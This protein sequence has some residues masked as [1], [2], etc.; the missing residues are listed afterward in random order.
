MPPIFQCG[1]HG[2]LPIFQYSEG[3]LPVLSRLLRSFTQLFGDGARID[4]ERRSAVLLIGGISLVVALALGLIGYGY[5]T[6]RIAPKH[7]LVLR[8]GDRQYDYA[9]IE[10]RI[11]SDLARGIFDTSNV[12]NS[13]STSVARIQREEIIRV[14]ARQHGLSASQE[15]IDA[16]IRDQLGLGD[17]VSHNE[18]AGILRQEVLR[19]ELPLHDYLE[20]V[21]ADALEAKLKAEFT[22]KL[23]PESE[24]V[25]LLLIA[26]GSQA[27]A[28]QARQALDA[29]KAF[30]DVAKTYSQDD[31]ASKGGEF[32]WAPRELLDPEL[33]DVAFNSTGRSGIIETKKDF[34][35][36]EVLEKQVKPIDDG[37]KQKIGNNEFRDLL[38]TA[39]KDTIFVSNFT[40]A[41]LIRLTNAIGG[42]PGG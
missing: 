36:I 40:Q 2:V 31:S 41:Q 19:V 29:G 10:R 4:P 37:Q 16:Q 20:T 17:D 26:A 15:D 42:A 5:Y 39:I 12:T 21:E 22:D 7:E 24:Q 3:G 38:D 14:V 34:Y 8:V 33:A 30:A 11:K 1:G 25:N 28:I 32:G 35:I 9:F 6:D 27:N 13:I 23:P 18:M